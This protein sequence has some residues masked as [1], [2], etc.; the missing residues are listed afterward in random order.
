MTRFEKI[1]GFAAIAAFVVYALACRPAR[2]P[3]STRI[4]YEYGNKE[5]K[6]LALHDLRTGETRSIITF[7]GRMRDSMI[8]NIWIDERIIL[9]CHQ[10]KKA[11]KENRRE[12]V[13]YDF[14][15]ST[16]ALLSNHTF[17]LNGV[18]ASPIVPPALDA[19]GNIWLGGIEKG[20][21]GFVKIDLAEK[22]LEAVGPEGIF[23]IAEGKDRIFYAKGDKEKGVIELGVFL[24]EE[25]EVSALAIMDDEEFRGC[26]IP[27]SLAAAPD[28]SRA[29]TSLT[30]KNGR[31]LLLF[32]NY[33]DGVVT[34][35]DIPLDVKSLGGLAYSGDSR[36]VW[37]A[38]VSRED[39][40]LPCLAKIDPEEGVTYK[41]PLPMKG[42]EFDTDSGI[43]LQPVISPDGKKLAIN[44]AY[45]VKNPATSGLYLL[46]LEDRSPAF[47]ELPLPTMRK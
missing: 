35:F 16:G 33:E 18:E 41:T 34:R 9:L 13:L 47:L 46:D 10:E 8:Q 29:C 12:I 36:S 4:T 15:S 44:T 19:K 26:G 2:S 30:L 21:H 40:K 28:G 7:A 3:D 23:V 38:Y 43:L 42:K 5:I 31:S 6:G 39:G 24:P 37:I 17:P 20:D 32:L 45:I 27:F 1:I 25:E 11:E 22:T 14:D